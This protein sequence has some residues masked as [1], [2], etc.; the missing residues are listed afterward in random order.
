MVDAQ[1]RIACIGMAEVVPERINRLPRMQSAQRVGPPL[2]EQCAIR[3]TELGPEQRIIDPALG[4]VDIELGWNDVVVARE[5]DGC[6][7]LEQ[8]RGVRDEALNPAEL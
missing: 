6:A 8:R 4:R 2:H 7:C 5:Y 3:L 1:P